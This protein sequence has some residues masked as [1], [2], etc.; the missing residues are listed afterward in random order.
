[1]SILT[2]ALCVYLWGWLVTTCAVTLCAFSE[3]GHRHFWRSAAAG[4]VWPMLIPLLAVWKLI[5]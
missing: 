3:T 2:A 1:M 5:E 4:A